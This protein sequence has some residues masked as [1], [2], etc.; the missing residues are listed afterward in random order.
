MARVLWKGRPEQERRYSRGSGCTSC[1]AV[2]GTK[3][4]EGALLRDLESASL[5]AARPPRKAVATWAKE[6]HLAE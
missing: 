1:W 6:R 2:E 5:R 3:P 4:A